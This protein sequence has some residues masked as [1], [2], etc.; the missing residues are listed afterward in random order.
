MTTSYGM[1]LE[2]VKSV[3]STLG[4]LKSD[5][6]AYLMSDLGIE[7]QRVTAVD[8]PIT[9]YVK[10]TT[11]ATISVCSTF[12]E[13]VDEGGGKQIEDMPFSVSRF[14]RNFDSNIYPFLVRE[15]AND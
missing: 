1:K 13:F 11:G 9:N 4:R 5:Q 15:A 7:G 14:I 3:L 12:Y 8:C 10:K 2:R 6:I